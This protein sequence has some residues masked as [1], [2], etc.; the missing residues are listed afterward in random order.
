MNFILYFIFVIAGMLLAPHDVVQTLK[1][2]S[3]RLFI[4]LV[5]MLSYFSVFLI[6]DNYPLEKT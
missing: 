3:S 5:L 6:K 4:P 1:A 2:S